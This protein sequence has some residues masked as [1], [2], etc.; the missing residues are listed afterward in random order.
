MDETAKHENRVFIVGELN[1]QNQLL[2]SYLEEKLGIKCQ[3]C[4]D[5]ILEPVRGE[6]AGFATLTLWDC[7]SNTIPLL[8]DML[9]GNKNR[10]YIHFAL[11]NYCAD[12]V[13]TRSILDKGIHGVFY[14]NDPPE[15]VAK[16]AIAILKG[17][18]WFPRNLMAKF[19]FESPPVSK[20]PSLGKALL[21]FR[22][23][24]ILQHIASGF[25]NSEIADELCISVHTVKTHLYNIF[26]KIDVPNRLQAALWAAR[27][28]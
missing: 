17:E 3:F 25:S 15:L 23:Q 12:C 11:F 24:E 22:E 21:S 10:K 26:K 2:K 20:E 4:S 28:L 16:G 8:L 18:L 13:I 9:E 14:K 1:L 19:L 27:N 6:K 5:V 7:L